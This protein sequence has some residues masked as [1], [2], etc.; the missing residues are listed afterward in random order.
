MLSIET[1]TLFSFEQTSQNIEI[2]EWVKCLKASGAKEI[3]KK[4]GGFVR[5]QK[6]LIKYLIIKIKIVILQI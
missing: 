3:N 4:G 6:H 5:G 1:K 2:D